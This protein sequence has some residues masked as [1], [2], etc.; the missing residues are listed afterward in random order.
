MSY[1]WSIFDILLNITK[2]TSYAS[3]LH[4]FLIMK[5]MTMHFYTLENTNLLFWECKSCLATKKRHLINFK[6]QSSGYIH[7]IFCISKPGCWIPQQIH[8]LTA[9]PYWLTHNIDR[10]TKV[11]V[12]FSA[13]HQTLV[14]GHRLFSPANAQGPQQSSF[15]QLCVS[16]CVYVCASLWGKTEAGDS[17]KRWRAVAV[18]HQLDIIREQC[19]VF[20]SVNSGQQSL[21]EW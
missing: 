19:L 4:I 9:L 15:Q 20:P 5:T 13:S 3:C 6:F 11:M 12:T 21:C 18:F 7:E 2:T 10:H 1:S 17:L 16:K 8:N 14:K